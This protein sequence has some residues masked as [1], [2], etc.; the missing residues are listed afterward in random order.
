M[1]PYT[2]PTNRLYPTMQVTDCLV[3]DSWLVREAGPL[4]MGQTEA[5]AST[6][7]HYY[8]PR[9]RPARWWSCEADGGFG[10]LGSFGVRLNANGTTRQHC[11]HVRAVRLRRL[12]RD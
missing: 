9:S 4:P 10:S 6:V 2:T 7:V 3:P 8:A 12:Q 1:K 11:A 5:S